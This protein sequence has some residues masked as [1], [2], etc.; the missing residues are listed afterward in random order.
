[1]ILVDVGHD[2]DNVVERTLVVGN[3]HADVGVVEQFFDVLMRNT[4]SYGAAVIGVTGS[5]LDSFGQLESFLRG[6]SILAVVFLAD[7]LI[8]FLNEC[9]AAT[10]DSGAEALA[11]SPC[12]VTVCIQAGCYAAFNDLGNQ[13]H[14]GLDTGETELKDEH[15]L[16]GVGMGRQLLSTEV[17]DHL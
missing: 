11:I 4:D 12:I 15:C 16:L 10:V 3:N 8:A 17:T 9:L 2:S 1:M 5:L 13:R 6:Q 7:D 14:I